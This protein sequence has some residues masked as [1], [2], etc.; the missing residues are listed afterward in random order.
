MTVADNY[1]RIQKAIKQA[2][3]LAG[4][5]SNINII[6]VTKYVS[7]QKTEEALRAGITHLGENRME[8]ALEKWEH[9][10]DKATL[11]FIGSLQSKKAKH[12]I[13]K[14]DYIHSLDRLSLAKELDKRCPEGRKIRCFVQVNV[15]GEDSKSGIQPDEAVDFI[16]SLK[17][18]A[19]VEVVGLMTMAPYEK[20][21]EDT[22]PI[23]RRLRELRDRI[24]SLNYPHAPCGE[25]S[26]G[27]SNDY[28]VA[29]EEGATYIRIGSLLVGNEQGNAK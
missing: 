15:S 14:Y 23:F 10:H 24:R 16:E 12:I 5:D 6:A 21:P 29:V 8:G 22:R 18:F 25:L 26:M 28:T 19:A 7:L 4:R 27:M 2:C 9:F 13:E 17:E 11:H 20:N 3:E 1:N